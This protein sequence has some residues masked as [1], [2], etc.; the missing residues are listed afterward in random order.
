[1]RKQ[2]LLLVDDNA[3][4][5]R[6]L[7]NALEEQGYAV[8]CAL[9]CEEAL[10]CIRQRPP[11]CALLD[12]NLDGA[13]GMGLIR[14]LR[15]A[16]QSCRIVMLTGYASIAT[17]V[18]A[19]KLGADHYLAKPVAVPDIVRAL[20][21]EGVLDKDAAADSPLSVRKLQW[22]HIQRVLAENHG[23][24]SAAARAL[25]MHRR[26]LQRKLARQPPE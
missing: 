11:Q 24:I 14:P 1:M 4:F 13:S 21:G 25:R 6:V 2:R 26:T 18:D 23:S 5:A 20:N 15:T 9:E 16:N 17:A 12:L 22:E 8:E 7:A 3:I 10:R 19:V